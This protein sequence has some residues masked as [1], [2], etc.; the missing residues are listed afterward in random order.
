[1]TKHELIFSTERRHILARH[2]IF[3]LTW[4]VL[5]A[6][7]FHY[8]IHSFF[9]WK[10]GGEQTDTVQ[11]F[12]L[13]AFILKT[14]VVNS[15]LSVVL[16]QIIFTYAFIYWLL[17]RFFYRKNNPLITGGTIALTLIAYL[18]V[19]LLFKYATP[20]LN[21]V[22]GFSESLVKMKIPVMLQF[23]VKDQLV[24]LPIVAGLAVM[25]KWIKRWWF[26]QKE[27]ELLAKEKAKA[28]LQLLKAQIHPHFLFNTLNNIY[29]FTLTNSAQAPEMIARLTA[30][31]HYV[32]NECNQ[33]MVPLKKELALIHD[34]MALEKIRYGN[35]MQM[36]IDAPEHIAE[37]QIAPLLLIPF[38]ENSFKHGT[39][40]M[41]A[42]PWVK[43]KV[44]TEDDFLFFAIS[45]SKPGVAGTSP[46]KS[47]IGLKNVR[48]RLQLLYPEK[49][50]LDITEEPESFSVFL[51][52]K[53][54][55][56]QAST[57]YIN[58]P[59]ITVEDAVA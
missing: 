35:K 38:V 33:P 46:V 39:S 27:T 40:K 2:F 51:K 23:V 42:Q 19:A 14:L 34:Y 54:S 30:M 20:L 58:D 53:L 48:Q 49:H 47:N 1:M 22:L 57:H 6:L 13:P 52:I 37:Q 44:L 4:L 9:G 15:F 25:I 18:F 28:E 45:N 29:F 55:N 21:Y 8:P 7:L 5:Y 3:W 26:K 43:L 59:K 41:V 50:R 31:L 12:G 16:P 17:P 10:I 24:T 11:K 32:L 56:K 36:M